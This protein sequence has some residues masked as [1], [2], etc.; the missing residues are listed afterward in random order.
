MWDTIG[1]HFCLQLFSHLDNYFI[2]M[3]SIFLHSACILPQHSCPSDG[4]H[5]FSLPSRPVVHHPLVSRL[6][7][8]PFLVVCHPPAPAPAW[9]NAIV[10][11]RHLTLMLTVPTH[12]HH[13]IDLII[14]SVSSYLPPPPHHR[15]VIIRRHFQLTPQ[16][17]SNAPTHR[18][19]RCTTTS[20]STTIFSCPVPLPPVPCLFSLFDCCFNVLGWAWR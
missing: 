3:T 8:P 7:P 14:L 19:R 10:H 20:S 16:A 18:N 6:P 5:L 9:L 11:C 1:S 2:S 15:L 17:P 12:R 4:S 13:P